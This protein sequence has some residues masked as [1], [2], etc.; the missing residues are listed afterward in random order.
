MDQNALAVRVHDSRLLT[1]AEKRYWTERLPR[2]N[3]Q[4][5]A[6]LDAILAEAEHLGW[7][8]TIPNYDVARTLIPQPA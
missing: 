7:N 5:L 6:K 2:M 1:E 3:A 4:Q 8:D